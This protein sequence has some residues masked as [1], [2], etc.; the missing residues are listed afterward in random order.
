[1]LLCLVSF[2]AVT[3]FATHTEALSQVSRRIM[4]NSL[5]AGAIAALTSTPPCQP[6]ATG[7]WIIASSCTFSGTV[8]APRS[9]IVNQGKVLT[10]A[11]NAKLRIDFKHYNLVVRKGGGV[12]IKKTAAVKQA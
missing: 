12:L 2:L 8:A 11:A 9:V 4:D 7:D 1:M 5:V 10:I 6:P 3:L